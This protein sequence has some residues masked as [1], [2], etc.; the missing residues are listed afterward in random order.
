MRVRIDFGLCESNA[1][2]TRILPEV[3]ELGDDD[4][5]RLRTEEIP[6]GRETAAEDAVRRCPRQAIELEDPRATPAPPSPPRTPA[7]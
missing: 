3:L 4:L 7:R 1:V 5:L 6:P 2:C